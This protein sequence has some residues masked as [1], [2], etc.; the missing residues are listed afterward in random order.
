MTSDRW[1]DAVASFAVPG[2]FPSYQSAAVLLRLARSELQ[3]DLIEN[4]E[5]TVGDFYALLDRVD[6]TPSRLD[7]NKIMA[8][9]YIIELE[10][11]DG[12]GKTTLCSKLSEAIPQSLNIKTPSVALKEIR[13]LWDKLGGV[14]ARA[15]Y[16]VSNYILQHEILECEESVVIIDR[17]YASTCAYTV[18]Y[19][20]KDATNLKALTPISELPDEVFKWPSDLFL[21]PHLLLIM[22][23]DPQVRRERVEARASTGG[24]ASR[25]NPWDDRLARSPELGFRILESFGRITGPREVQSVDANLSIEKVVESAM[26]VI[27]PALQRHFRPQA[28]FASDP[29]G[30]WKF[31]SQQLDLCDDSGNRKHHALWNLQVS[32]CTSLIGPPVLKTVGL[33][34]IDDSCLYYWTSSGTPATTANQVWTSVLWCSG[35]Y[36]LESQFRAEGYLERVT[37]EECDLRGFEAPQSLVA[38][39]TACARHEDQIC[40]DETRRPARPDSYDD[41]VEKSRQKP[42]L[43]TVCLIRFVPIRIE[44]LKGGPSTRIAGFPQRFEFVRSGDGE[45][46]IRSILPFSRAFSTLDLS[47]RNVTIA[48]VGT[49]GSGKSTIGERLAALLG[50][51]NDPELGCVLRNSDN[52]VAGGHT[53]GDGSTR[54]D[55]SSEP[56]GWDKHVHR[57]ECNRDRECSVSRVVET[58]HVGN[59]AW[60]GMRLEKAIDNSDLPEITDEDWYRLGSWYL[61][62]IS[63]HLQ[64]TAVLIVQLALDSPSTTLRRRGRYESMRKRLPMLDEEKE[65]NE[66]QHYLQDK[67]ED[68]LSVLAK[69]FDIPL[70][71]I[72]NSND[73][74]EAMERVLKQIICFVR[75]NLY[76]RVVATST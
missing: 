16:H 25:F 45:Y 10:G 46:E 49:H 71:R 54:P 42:V 50:Y 53:Y 47:I 22:Q 24:G 69:N 19:P 8:T 34:R 64:R 30:W 31:E 58:W 60:L 36:P 14:L 37:T 73:G 3:V 2:L 26:G 70:L 20:N 35:E 52:L 27:K 23:I 33:D 43:A 62:A 63:E 67:M 68:N 21:R 57:Q 17:W 38:H 59:S 7:I 5:A 55:S 65:C 15:F 61:D 4:G 18:G 74:D 48:L 28:Y 44:V 75:K 76:R 51:R 6:R 1:V 40:N 11:L 9:K 39:M 56:F 41:L 72:D 12:S 13:P 29:L 66:L 32:H